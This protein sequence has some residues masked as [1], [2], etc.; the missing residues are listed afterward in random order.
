M[1]L[2]AGMAR[3]SFLQAS[4]PPAEAPI[5]TMRKSPDWR[6]AGTTDDGRSLVRGLAFFRGGTRLP[7]ILYLFLDQRYTDRD[8]LEMQ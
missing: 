4:K 7:G 2:A 5:P 8:D 3:T 1:P 6:G